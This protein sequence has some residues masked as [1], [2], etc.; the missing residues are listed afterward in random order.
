MNPPRVED[1]DIVRSGQLRQAGQSSEREQQKEQQFLHT[2]TG[3]SM[4]PW[5]T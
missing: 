5:Q 2:E 3:D 4:R 1:N